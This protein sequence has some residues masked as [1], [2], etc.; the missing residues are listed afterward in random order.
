MNHGS[1]SPVRLA[2]LNGLLDLAVPTSAKLSRYQREISAKLARKIAPENLFNSYINEIASRKKITA[3]NYF[4]LPNPP[5]RRGKKV[6]N[7]REKGGKL[8]CKSIILLKI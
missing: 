3:K 6:G 7:K 4:P 8:N 1:T 5:G 2:I